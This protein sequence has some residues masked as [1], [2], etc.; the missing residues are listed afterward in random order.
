MFA[1]T[2]IGHVAKLITETRPLKN[3]ARHVHLLSKTK[4]MLNESLTF[5][6]NII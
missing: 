6:G 4:E 3:V 5:R 1:Y 2:R